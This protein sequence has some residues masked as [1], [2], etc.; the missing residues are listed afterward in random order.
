MN[1][2]HK[3]KCYI[4]G[5]EFMGSDSDECPYC[6]WGYTGIEALNDPNEKDAY[7][8]MS[9]EEA[10]KRFASGTDIYNRPLGKKKQ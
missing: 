7:N 2:N 8:L 3:I 1:Y 9:I 4:C 10:K 5:T 6:Y